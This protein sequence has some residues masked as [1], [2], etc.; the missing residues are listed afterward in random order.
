MADLV[1]RTAYLIRQAAHCL[2]FTGAGVSVES[3]IP[4]FRGAGGIWEKYDPEILEINYFKQHPEQ[5]WKF[6][7]NIFYKEMSRAVPNQG[8]LLLADLQRAGHIKC[9]ITQNIDGLHQQAGSMKVIEYHGSV[10]RLVCIGCGR[11]VNSGDFWL[12]PVPGC[13]K[14]HSLLKPDFIFFGEPLSEEVLRDVQIELSKTDLLIVIGASGEVWPAAR[15]PFEAK[16]RGAKIIEVN[17]SIS[18]YSDT[19]ADVFIQTPVSEFAQK[20][21]PYFFS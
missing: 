9:L 21:K 3:G 14:C 4:P 6:I 20:I 2:V 11:I 10:R 1:E 5:S 15:I 19:I 13:R 18:R 12:E 8:H 17:P 7:R 16:Q